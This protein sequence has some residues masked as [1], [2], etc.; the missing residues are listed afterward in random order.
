MVWPLTFSSVLLQECQRSHPNIFRL[1]LE[2]VIFEGHNI[3]ED[4]ILH[5]LEK[6][7][8][9]FVDNIIRTERWA[10]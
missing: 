10:T 3:Q 9:D 4:G 7:V 2:N 8:F 1:F 6:F 5:S